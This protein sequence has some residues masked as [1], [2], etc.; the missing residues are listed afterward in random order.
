MKVLEVEAEIKVNSDGVDKGLQEASNK[1]SQFAGKTGDADKA[2]KSL[3]R[4]TVAGAAGLAA[5]GAMSVKT[6]AKFDQSMSQVAATMGVT[7]DEIQDLRNFAMDMGKTTAFSATEA[8]DALNYMALAGYDADMSMKMLPNVLNLAAAGGIDLA[9]ASDMVTDAQTAFGISA[10]RTTQMVD[11]MA[12]AA[13]TGN[14]SVEQLGDAFLVVGGL[15]KELNGG[16]V[17]LSDGTQAS[18]DG[19]QEMEIVLTAMA[20]AGIKGS[21]AGTHLRN[22]IMKLSSPTSDGA[23]QMEALGVQVFDAEGKMRS[24]HDIMG[25]L[26]SALSTLTQEEKIQAISDLFNARDLSSAEALL[27][28]VEGDWDAIGESILDAKGAAQQM[29]DTQLDNLAGDITLLKSAFEGLQI[30]VSDKLTPYLRIFVQKLTDLIPHLGEIAGAISPVVAGFAAFSAVVISVRVVIPA[31][32]QNVANFFALLAAN[33]IALAIGLMAGL[34]VMVYRLATHFGE[35]YTKADESAE[36]IRNLN[37]ATES[38][39]TAFAKADAAAGH[40]LESIESKLRVMGVELAARSGENGT[41]SGEAFVQGHIQSLYEIDPQLAQIMA[42][43][44]NTS[45]SMSGENG[46]LSGDAYVSSYD[47]SALDP[48]VAAVLEQV[49]ATTTSL[50]QQNAQSGVNAYTAEWSNGQVPAA[51]QGAMGEANSAGQAGAVQFGQVGTSMVSEACANIAA[52]A[53]QVSSAARGVVVTAFTVANAATSM[54]VSVGRNIAAGIARG[55]SAGSP[56]IAAAARSAVSSALAA[57]KAAAA[58]ASPSRKFRDEVGYFM[59]LGV[60]KGLEDSEDEVTKAAVKLAQDTYRNAQEWIRRTAKMDKWSLKDQLEVW[61]E[62]QKGFIKGSQQ[63]LDAEEEI[64]D[65][66]E[67]IAEEHYNNERKRIEKQTKRNHLSLI[68]QLAE[69]EKLRDAYEKNSEEY[70]EIDDKVFDLREDIQ[71]DFRSNVEN[72]WKNIGDIYDKYTDKLTSR[73]E[74]IADSYGLFDDVQDRTRLSADELIMNLQRQVNVM[75]SF[76]EELDQLAERGASEEM[77]QQIRDMGPQA[78]DQLDALLAMTDKQW[79]KYVSLFGEKQAIAN[80]TA[81]KELAGLREDTSK[82]ILD[83]L[84]ELNKLYE[85]NSE[86]LGETFVTQVAKGIEDSMGAV[87]QA[88]TNLAREANAAFYSA[89]DIEYKSQVMPFGGS[90]LGASSAQIVNTIASTNQAAG[91]T[92]N[93]N[94]NIDG[95]TVARMTFDPLKNYAASKGQP[96]VAAT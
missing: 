82:E 43:L 83:Q 20:N 51:V 62:V 59:G 31:L 67:S 81:L 92:Y 94:M 18:V 33:P 71:D 87:V 65:L 27:A 17:T 34:A 86:V 53:Q 64:F 29:A 90:G 10:E 2:L 39:V 73:I 46:A 54:F 93:I 69:W 78:I 26:N 41:V 4:L 45:V 32:I 47:I 3:T 50:S 68:Q 19:L 61:Q 25:D 42:T 76:Y 52:S 57:A 12:K 6:G 5:F 24:L 1:V 22:M 44:T 13:S 84:E 80:D 16:L 40:A 35:L 60:A 56:A 66:R 8:A 72:I 49:G 79:D 96:I 91:G 63:W 55:I 70:A 88:A 48:E 30:E 58:I 14:T 37:R 77:V 15:A 21:E 9:R 95:T 75:G 28:A 38:T 36:G 11:E 74:E 89:L 85:D 7:V 23:K